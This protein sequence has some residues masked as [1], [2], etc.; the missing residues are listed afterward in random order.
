L[1]YT[2]RFQHDLKRSCFLLSTPN[3]YTRN[4]T[5]LFQFLK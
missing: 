2:N 3:Y 5:R 4:A 1:E